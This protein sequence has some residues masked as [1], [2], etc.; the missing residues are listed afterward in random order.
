MRSFLKRRIFSTFLFSWAG[1]RQAWRTEEAFRVEVMAF[2]VLM[3]LGL[4]LGHSGAE[5]AL[6]VGSLGIILIVE[7]LNTGLEKVVDR[8]SLEQHSLSK[9]VKDIGSAAVLLSL[10]VAGTVWA[11]VLF[12]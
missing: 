5:K 4:Y 2:V 12:A 1:L 10:V 7:L 11:L 3:P 6:L 8:I 9:T